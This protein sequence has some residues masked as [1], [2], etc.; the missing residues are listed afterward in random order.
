[1]RRISIRTLGTA[2]CLL[3]VIIATAGCRSDASHTERG[4]V[5]G[6]LL[7]AGAGALVG[8][9]S[10]HAG[11][12]ALI[13]GAAGALAGAAIG[14]DIDAEEARNR[15]L[16]EAQLGRQLATGSVTNGEVI[17][18]V[19][20]H[21][22]DDLIINHIRAHGM[23]APPTAND[24]ITLQQCGVSPRVVEVMQTS[25]P[26]APRVQT[27]VVH[28]DPPPVVIRTYDPYWGPP[29]RYHRCWW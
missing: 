24:L 21:V 17:S 19:Q 14:S 26:P 8:S 16:I 27:V 6:G 7:G 10:G 4:A 13:G 20:A 23:V 9:A 11:A 2:G 29:P 5:G 28:E 15:R 1:M 18:M 22:S 25:R 3:A 12:G